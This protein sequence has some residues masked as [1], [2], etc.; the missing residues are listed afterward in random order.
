MINTLIERDL[1]SM[2]RRKK[3]MG[4]INPVLNKLVDAVHTHTHTNYP[5]DLY[6]DIEQTIRKYK[7]KR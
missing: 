5:E 1:W 6:E 2:D 7:K 4:K 3:A